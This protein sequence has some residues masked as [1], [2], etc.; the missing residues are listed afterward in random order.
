[1][2]TRH[3]RF[4]AL[5][6]ILL[7]C[8][9]T[10]TF[11]L[12]LNY[13]AA[14]AAQVCNNGDSIT[15]GKYWLNNNLW[16]ASTGSGSQCISDTSINGSTIAWQ[17]SWNWTGQTNAVKSYDSSVLGWHWGWKISNTGLPIQLSSNQP[18]QTS[19]SY[20]FNQTTAGGYDVS[21]DTWLSPNA[22]L[23]NANPSN[24]VM[25]WLSHGGGV[26]PV[27]SKQTTVTIDG[28]SWD[29]WEGSA[30]WQVDSFVRTSNTSSQSLNLMDFYNYLISRGLSSSDYLLSVESGTEIFTGAGS[31][32]TTSYS[33]NVGT[34][35]G[36]GTPTPTPIPTNT[37]TP[38]P[39]S[40]P[41]AGGVHVG[42][43]VASQWTGG[44]SANITITNNSSTTING[45]KLQFAFPGTQQVTQLWNG[46]VSQ[47][48]NQVTVT[49]LSYNGT[50]A[51]GQSV[52][53]GFNGSWSG[54][55]PSPT[56]FT[57]N[58]SPTS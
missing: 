30:S 35:S 7:A 25:I 31:L 16:G 32:N 37:P 43:Q 38:I 53:L 20:N 40:T 8:I 14:R 58:G 48:G 10:T 6:R 23:G 28:T 26:S 44:F 3:S 45:W 21:Y 24:E 55:N 33:T 39:T 36:G 27:G 46:S 56:S 52:S 22:N 12:L 4:P 5:I 42:Y 9:F 57:L 13:Q 49:N 2:F 34:G 50:I 47:T 18:V 54:S 29:L 11:I 19:W 17:T 15:M 1:M 41:I 51:P